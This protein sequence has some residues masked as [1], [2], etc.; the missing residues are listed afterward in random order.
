M[1]DQKPTYDFKVLFFHLIKRGRVG[2]DIVRLF[3]PGS[4]REIGR[5]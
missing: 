1:S 3:A 4:N 5:T 2:S